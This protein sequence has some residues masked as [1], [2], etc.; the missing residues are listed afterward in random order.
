MSSTKEVSSYLIRILLSLTVR[1]Q[2][3]SELEYF[4]LTP[5]QTFLEL[6]TVVT[7]IW[8][9][10][11]ARWRILPQIMMPKIRD[12]LNLCRKKFLRA[13]MMRPS[14]W[15]LPLRTTVKK[16]SNTIQVYQLAN[17]RKSQRRRNQNFQRS[18]SC[19]LLVEKSLWQV[20][21]EAKQLVQ[22]VG[23]ALNMT[24]IVLK[25]VAS[26]VLAPL[27]SQKCALSWVT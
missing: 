27:T 3:F 14:T 13:T 12:S 7:T 2:L 21:T 20:L 1:F 26:S 22:F 23:K 4:K 11:I 10:S 19:N 25:V 18:N 8:H 17:L 9:L 15:D 6:T 16:M 24:R 5:H